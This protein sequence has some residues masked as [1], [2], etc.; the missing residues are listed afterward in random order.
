[1]TAI[2]GGSERVPGVATL[3]LLAFPSGPPSHT[4]R[5]WEQKPSVMAPQSSSGS[6]MRLTS[7]EFSVI[8]RRRRHTGCPPALPGARPQL[9][10]QGDPPSAG[11]RAWRPSAGSRRAGGPHSDCRISWGGASQE[12][13]PGGKKGRWRWESWVR[14]IG[15]PG[16]GI[17]ALP[18]N[19]WCSLLVNCGWE[20]RGG[21]EEDNGAPEPQLQQP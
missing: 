12:G 18:V 2:S 15:R 6:G 5:G 21:S 1:M 10:D 3:R 13:L 16:G 19:E 7:A 14:A 8:H 11:R 20:W 9:G 4:R 17:G